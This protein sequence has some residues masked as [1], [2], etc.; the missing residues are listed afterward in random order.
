MAKRRNQPERK[1][2]LQVT[3][4][5]ARALPD[6]AFYFPVP[7]AANFD[8]IRGARLRQS[9]EIRAG[10]PDL[11]VIWAGKVIAVELK[12]PQGGGLSPV[13]R[14]V[15]DLMLLAGCTHHI[16]RTI[17]QLHEALESYQMPLKVRL[18]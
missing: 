15:R 6:N 16:V 8:P 1:L 18:V 5:L 12:A 11:I 9:G 13:Q 4:Y 17:E 14:D 10:V 3:Q 7:N 2:H